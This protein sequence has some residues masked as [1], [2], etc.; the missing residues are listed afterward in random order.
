MQLP[1]PNKPYLLFTDTSKFCYS[2]VFT[3]TSTEDSNEALFRILTSEDPLKT[4][5]SQTQDLQLESKL[6]HPVA[7]IS[8]SFSQSQCRCLQFQK[9][10]S[11]SLCQLRNVP[12][13]C[14][15]PTY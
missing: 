3:Q 4:M 12:F 9:S 2:G 8:V 14:K 6:V 15:M 13:T 1:D 11:V 7:F 5:E 10:D